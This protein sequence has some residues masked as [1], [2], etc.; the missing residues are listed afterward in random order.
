[1]EGEPVL[2]EN[3]ARLKRL[4]TEAEKAKEEEVSIHDSLEAKE[5]L[6]ARALDENE[7]LDITN[8]TLIFCPIALQFCG[9]T[10]SLWL[11]SSLLVVQELVHKKI[12][13]H[14]S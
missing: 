9:E 1:M 2:G 6:L 10:L 12:Y 3:P 11:K 4:K 13:M 8:V 5:A 14:Y 7:V